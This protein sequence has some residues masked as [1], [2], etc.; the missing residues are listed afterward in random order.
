MTGIRLPSPR[1]DHS[2]HKIDAGPEAGER[3]VAA[4]RD[5]PKPLDRREEILDLAP[6]FL[7]LPVAVAHD[8]P[9]GFSRCCRHAAARF[10]LLCQPVGVEGLANDGAPVIQAV[11]QGRQVRKIVRLP[12]NRPEAVLAARGFDRRHDL[13]RRISPGSAERLRGAPPLPAAV[14]EHGRT[15][16]PPACARSRSNDLD[17]SLKIPCAS[18]RRKRMKT[19][20]QLPNSDGAPLPKKV[21]V[22]RRPSRRAPPAGKLVLDLVPH[23][24][25]RDKPARNHGY[26]LAF[27]FDS[28]L[29]GS[30]WQKIR[31]S[32]LRIK[33]F[34]Q[35]TLRADEKLFSTTANFAGT[36]NG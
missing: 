28:C 22:G 14:F 4:R 24:V 18:R 3:L 16:V 33:S 34:C 10:K 26:A 32:K 1:R 25:G 15:A 13:C 35:K 6:P 29:F 11:R 19:L 30:C 7:H 17:N 23:S 2:R 36:E 21:A 27:C 9:A 8:L 12:G 20:F 5:C 31:R